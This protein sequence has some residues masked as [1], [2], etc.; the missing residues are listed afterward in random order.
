MLQVRIVLNKADQVDHHEL[1]RVY[2]ALMWS[3]SKVINVPECPKVFVGSFWDQ[4]LK[5]DLYRKLF[6]KELQ[7]LFDDLQD[8]PKYAAIRKIN[9]FIKRARMAKIHAFIISSLKADMPKLIGKSRKKKE[10]IRNLPVMFK[11]VQEDHMV[12]AS[13]IPPVS[14]M[15]EKLALCDFSKFPTLKERLINA[16]DVMLDKDVA[17]LVALVPRGPESDAPITGGAFDDVK[18]QISPF[19]YQR[20]EGID[21][22][23]GEP[24]WIVTKERSKWDA[25]FRQLGPINGK[26]TG[27]TAKKEMIKSRLTN[28]VLA[29]IWRLSDVDH[30]G[31]LDS[32]EF[33]LAMHLIHI[34]LEGFDLPEDLPGHLIPPSKKHRLSL[35]NGGSRNGSSNNG[36]NGRRKS[37]LS[38]EAV[39]GAGGV[40][41]AA[42]GRGSGEEDAGY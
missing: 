2:G 10:L 33:A 32:D 15:Q 29:K 14:T 16:V 24:E 7:L 11:K 40:A 6:E 8:L 17:S 35:V 42:E 34:K 20:C 23:S 37:G 12:S 28:P 39:G 41:A 31:M 13:D 3:I 18:D 21:L 9:D 1:M 27:S 26:I 36:G 30:D 38:E 5:H 19:G 22:G 4:Q 25:I